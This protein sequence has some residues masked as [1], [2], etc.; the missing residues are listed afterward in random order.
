MA[1]LALGQREE[2]NNSMTKTSNMNIKVN[3]AETVDGAKHDY[4]ITGLQPEHM[5]II[6]DLV[7]E[8]ATQTDRKMK[9]LATMKEPTKASQ[10]DLKDITPICSASAQILYALTHANKI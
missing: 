4:S 10:A 3:Y 5:V 2:K 9:Q 1:I 7:R 8:H 6:F